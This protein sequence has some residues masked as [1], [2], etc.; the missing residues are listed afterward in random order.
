MRMSA[1]TGTSWEALLNCVEVHVKNRSFEREWT[2]N[3]DGYHIPY[4]QKK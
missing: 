3:N 4:L 1:F 2:V